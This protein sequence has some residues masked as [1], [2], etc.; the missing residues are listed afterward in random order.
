MS[1]AFAVSVDWVRGK[2]FGNQIR[3]DF[4]GGLKG[5]GLL[6]EMLFKLVVRLGFR[7]VNL[8]GELSGNLELGLVYLEL[9]TEGVILMGDTGLLIGGLGWA[10]IMIEILNVYT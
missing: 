10:L 9:V 2:R 3:D 4:D 5:W 8:E 7:E 1:L 6:V